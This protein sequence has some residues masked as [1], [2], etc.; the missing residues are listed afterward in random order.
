MINEAE[1]VQSVKLIGQVLTLFNVAIQTL[2]MID[3]EKAGFLLTSTVNR[4]TFLWNT[5]LLLV[6]NA[7]ILLQECIR[8]DVR[9]DL[10]PPGKENS[11]AWWEWQRTSFR[12]AR[13][14]KEVGDNLVGVMIDQIKMLYV[15]GEV[16]N[17]LLPVTGM[18]LAV[19]FVYVY[20][21]GGDCLRKMLFGGSKCDFIT[22]RQ[23]EKAQILVPLLL[24]ME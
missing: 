10:T 3:C 19:R 14:E 18:Y 6:T 1:S 21:I 4:V 8:D 17:V 15:F 12:S 13:A 9:W 5:Y 23:A 2:V 7:F 16:A 22:V 11:E 20:N 24:W